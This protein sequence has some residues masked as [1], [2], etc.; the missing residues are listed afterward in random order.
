MIVE[1]GDPSKVFYILKEGKLKAEMGLDLLMNNKYPVDRQSWEVLTTTKR[2][3]HFLKE[4]RPGEH[5][6]HEEILEG[7]IPRKRRVSAA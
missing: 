6:G 5:F 1:Q 2:I 3:L 4:I 7:G